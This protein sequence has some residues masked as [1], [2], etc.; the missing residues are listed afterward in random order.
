M[1]PAWRLSQRCC[2]VV[3][4]FVLGAIARSVATLL[5]FPY[6][7]AKVLVQTKKKQVVSGQAASQDGIVS[8][9]QRVYKEEG[10][11][12]LYRGLGPELTKARFV[13]ANG[14]WSMAHLLLLLLQ[15]ALSS[16][17]ML[18]VKEKIQAYVTLML[19]LASAKK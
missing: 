3:Q 19:V 4:A 1:S 11:L 16:A 15:G 13:L 5:L 2:G 12:S 9:L 17:F 18:M 14:C 10:A 8:T 6:I 7:R